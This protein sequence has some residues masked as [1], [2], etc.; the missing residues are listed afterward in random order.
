MMRAAIQLVAALTPVLLF[1]RAVDCD[2]AELHLYEIALYPNTFLLCSSRY[3]VRFAPFRSY[4]CGVARSCLAQNNWTDATV[5]PANLYRL[6]SC[7]A[8]AIDPRESGSELMSY[9]PCMRKVFRQSLLVVNISETVHFQ[10]DVNFV[11]SC[12]KVSK[13]S[14]PGTLRPSAQHVGQKEGRARLMA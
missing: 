8:H 11:C 6:D 7:I 4:E 2:V 10:S 13:S 12:D 9:P 1:D 5:D 14:R 3:A